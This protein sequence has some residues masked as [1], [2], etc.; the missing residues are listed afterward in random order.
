[1]TLDLAVLGAQAENYAAVP[2][3]L[4]KLKLTDDSGEPVHAVALR[5]QIRIEP[6][7]RT[8]TDV[9]QGRLY[10]LFDEPKRWGETLKPLSWCH[11]QLM[12]T[13]FEES[14]EVDLAMPCSYDFEVVGNKYLHSVRDGDIPLQFLFSGSIFTKGETGF[15]AQ[16]V[17][18]NKDVSFMMPA[19][20]WQDVMDMYFPNSGWMKVRRDVMDRLIQYKTRQAMPSWE[21]AFETLL[22]EAGQ[23]V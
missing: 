18:W 5:I 8:Y 22:K 9:D 21:Q 23:D 6:Q 4:F 12:V 19:K 1:M 15:A 17:G 3:I 16:P 10:E 2:T 20:V 14:T 7:R 11:T 13:R